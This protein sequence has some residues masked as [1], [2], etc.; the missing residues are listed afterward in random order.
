MYDA[1]YDIVS[2]VR[3]WK[4]YSQTAEVHSVAVDGTSKL[5]NASAPT[6][7]IDIPLQMKQQHVA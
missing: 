2:F 7:A 6:H 5:N 3:T 4:S 1:V